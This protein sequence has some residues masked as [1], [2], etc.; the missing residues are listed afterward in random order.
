[1]PVAVV[2]DD[3][4]EPLGQIDIAQEPD[5]AVAQQPLHGGIEIELEG[6]G[7]LVVEPVDLGVERD[8]AVA[9]AHGGKRRGDAGR[10]RTGLV[11][12]PHHELRPAAIDDRIG[13]LRGDD[14]AAQPVLLE[15][16]GELF[17]DRAGEIALQLAPEIGIVGNVGLQ[18]LVLE[19]ELGIGQQHRQLRPRQRLR[20]PPPLVELLVVRQ[21]LDRAVEQV[22]AFE[23]LH[24]PLMKKP[25]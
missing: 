20:P 18:Q 21:V 14:L 3:A 15:R 8:H 5:H 6:A 19:R 11:F 16:V 24:Q 17:D 2:R 13:E 12:D 9:V 10:G 25:R 22:L 4:S 23:R 7:N 1:M